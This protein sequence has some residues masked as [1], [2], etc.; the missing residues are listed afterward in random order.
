MVSNHWQWID[1]VTYQVSSASVAQKVLMLVEK[2]RANKRKAM[3]TWDRTY[4]F[5]TERSI[6]QRLEFK[7]GWEGI[8][9]SAVSSVG[10]LWN[11][12]IQNS[13]PFKGRL[14]EHAC[15]HFN[16]HCP[17]PMISRHP[18]FLV[19]NREN[20]LLLL[21]AISNNSGLCGCQ[22]W[23]QL[24]QDQGALQSVVSVCGR[25]IHWIHISYWLK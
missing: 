12:C 8:T 2:Q 19:N 5:A 20:V 22:R 3:A 1:R 15:N 14:L 7:W 6:T 24:S 11:T 16:A 17:L 13:L 10:Q 9:I 4:A 21:Y 23:H 18:L 25:R